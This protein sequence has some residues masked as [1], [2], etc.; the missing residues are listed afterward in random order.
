MDALISGHTPE[1]MNGT[2]GLAA[3]FLK[4]A[5]MGD[6]AFADLDSA[7]LAQSIAFDMATN[8]VG[9]AGLAFAFLHGDIGAIMSALPAYAELFSWE[10]LQDILPNL[11]G[12]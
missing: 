8:P 10:E 9:A 11:E 3:S 1:N 4:N 12:L 6:T 5:R 2:E 7:V